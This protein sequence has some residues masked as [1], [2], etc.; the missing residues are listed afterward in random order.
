MNSTKFFGL[1]FYRS[2]CSMIK[3][4]IQYRVAHAQRLLLVSDKPINEIAL[5][6]G[7]GSVSQFYTVFKQA[8]G[9]PP[10][11]YRAAFRLI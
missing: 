6:A 9:Q 4:L 3:S 2:H 11:Q 8:C 5:E 1:Q 7:F 10:K